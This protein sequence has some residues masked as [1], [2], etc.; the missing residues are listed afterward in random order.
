MREMV[1][2][3]GNANRDWNEGVTLRVEYF[4]HWVWVYRVAQNAKMVKRR[5]NTLI[6]V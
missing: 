6:E 5:I 4:P 3:P 1:L 2:P